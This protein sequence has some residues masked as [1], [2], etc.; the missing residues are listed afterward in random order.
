MCI[1]LYLLLQVSRLRVND[2][3]IYQCVVRTRNGADFKG[4]KLSV[5][6]KE[7]FLTHG[8]C[9]NTAIVQKKMRLRRVRG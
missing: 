5:T 9:T 4:I 2:T 3:G 6:G 8:F 7:H 1:L